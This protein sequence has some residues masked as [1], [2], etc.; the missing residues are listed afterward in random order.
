MPSD[1]IIYETSRYVYHLTPESNLNGIIEKGL[2]PQCG[3]NC[4]RIDDISVGIHFAPSLDDILNFWVDAL[5]DEKD[6]ESLKIL[7][8]NVQNRRIKELCSAVYPA[9]G[10]WIALDKINPEEIDYL[11]NPNEEYVEYFEEKQMWL[12]IK[13]YQLTKSIRND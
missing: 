11:T 9:P 1:I 13:H 2:I 3:P 7:R 5:Y 10:D 12:P 4:K 8:F 6:I